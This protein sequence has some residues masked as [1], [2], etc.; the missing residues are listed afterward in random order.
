MPKLCLYVRSLY[1]TTQKKTT[2]IKKKLCSFLK[3]MVGTLS[4][5]CTATG[6]RCFKIVVCSAWCDKK[7]LNEKLENLEFLMS[8]LKGL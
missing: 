5:T 1:Y 7:N 3:T 6:Y 4:A 8:R 2:L